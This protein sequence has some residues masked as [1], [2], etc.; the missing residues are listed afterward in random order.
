MHTVAAAALTEQPL[1]KGW[2]DGLTADEVSMC[3]EF[4]DRAVSRKI[5]VPL[6]NICVEHA[7]RMP[8]KDDEIAGKIDALFY[9]ENWVRID[10]HK[11]VSSSRW[12]LSGEDL[13]TD[14]PMM[15]YAGYA[16][17][18]APQAD[19]VVLRHNY[20]IRDTMDTRF[21]EVEIPRAEVRSFW[22]KRIMPLLAEMGGVRLMQHWADVPGHDRKSEACNRYNGCSFTSICHGGLP[23]EQFGAV[24][25]SESGAPF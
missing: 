13:R 3:M 10:D 9:G 21:V 17:G 5:L 8:V 24:Q 11:V 12:C 25:T 18:Q 7:F 20:F 22:A 2:A 16:L 6:P 19:T 15:V 1:V 14:I 23:I 4:V